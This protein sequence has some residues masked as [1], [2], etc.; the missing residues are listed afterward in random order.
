[1]KISYFCRRAQSGLLQDSP[2]IQSP[3]ICQ[4]VGSFDMFRH[5][6]LNLDS[7]DEFQGSLD[8]FGP[9]KKFRISAEELSQLFC[10]IHRKFKVLIFANF[11]V[12]L[13]NLGIFSV[14]LDLLD[15]F[16]GH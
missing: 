16:H 2:K 9:F 8:E 1:M 3:N 4:Y 13:I 12:D 7:F 14:N 6:R 15:E 10:R 11:W 5:F